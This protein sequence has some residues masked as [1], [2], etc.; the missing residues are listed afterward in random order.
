[1]RS[2]LA[3]SA[4][5]TLPLLF[6][7]AAFAQRG[8]AAATTQGAPAASPAA[9]ASTM[10]PSTPI[11]SSTA[12]LSKT[13]MEFVTKAAQGGAAEVQMAQAALQKSQD[14]SVKQFAQTM[15][16]DHTPANAKLAQIATS[17][18]MTAPTDPSPAQQ[19][20]LAKLQGLDGAKFDHA[21]IAGQTKSHQ[22]ML[23]LFEHEATNGTDTD[24]KSFAESTQ[25][26]IQK[27]LTMAQN[28]KS[29]GK[30]ASGT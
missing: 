8:T 18:G 13:D 26:V 17:K 22:T 12:K 19:K 14:A 28:V 23:K 1:M 3:L 4:A 9:P 2:N 11:P 30:T 15:I 7:T 5:L 24:L 20:M 27:H 21:Y 10:A 29:T 6:T 16:D 25:P